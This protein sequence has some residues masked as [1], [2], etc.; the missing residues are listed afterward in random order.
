M[1]AFFRGMGASRSSLQHKG[2]QK[3]MF[4]NNRAEFWDS[5]LSF[6]IYLR[7]KH[8][9]LPAL[10]HTWCLN[11]QISKHIL[12]QGLKLFIFVIKIYSSF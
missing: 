7:V 5:F 3:T 2:K 11:D 8:F 6:L 12:E 9:A 10:L 1:L 4:V